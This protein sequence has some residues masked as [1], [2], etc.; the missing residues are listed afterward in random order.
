[1]LRGDQP[2]VAGLQRF[3]ILGPPAYAHTVE[4][5]TTKFG[6]ITYLG[7]RHVLRLNISQHKRLGSG[8]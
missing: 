7:K 1:M 8:Q 3:Q 5:T 4:P 2:K 6:V